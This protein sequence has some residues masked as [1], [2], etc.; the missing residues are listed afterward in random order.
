M[1]C[2]L[3]EEAKEQKK[4]NSVKKKQKKMD[5]KSTARDKRYSLVVSVFTWKPEPNNNSPGYCKLYLFRRQLYGPLLCHWALYFQWNNGYEA[6]YEADEEKGLLVPRW[7]VGPL[8]SGQPG[9]SPYV[10]FSKHRY[11]NVHC[12]PREVNDSAFNIPFNWKDY[13]LPTQNCQK[14][15][16]RLALTFKVILPDNDLTANQSKEHFYIN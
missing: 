3:S 6:T 12:S 13:F 4:I 16:K 8:E 9:G 2:F 5:R 14:W 7:K 1:A 11:D 10:W 15:A